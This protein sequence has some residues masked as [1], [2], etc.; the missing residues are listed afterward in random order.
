MN[1]IKGRLDDESS[2]DNNLTLSK[3]YDQNEVV[4]DNDG[5]KKPKLHSFKTKINELTNK[6]YTDNLGMYF[7]RIF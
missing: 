6:K 3:S 4:D 2:D 1:F 5:R 7:L